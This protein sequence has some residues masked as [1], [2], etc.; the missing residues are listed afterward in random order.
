M[1]D[2][3]FPDRLPADVNWHTRAVPL[4]RPEARLSDEQAA[5]LR[6]EVSGEVLKVT[7]RKRWNSICFDVAASSRRTPDWKSI[8]RLRGVGRRL[9]RVASDSR[10]CTYRW[11][12]ETALSGDRLIAIPLAAEG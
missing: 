5:V 9:R 3:S 1:D 11:D 6:K 10:P 2:A 7:T 8:G 12:G 4:L